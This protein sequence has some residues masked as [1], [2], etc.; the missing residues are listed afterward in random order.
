MR[1]KMI[2]ILWLLAVASVASAD[3]SYD[4]QNY[5]EGSNIGPYTCSDGEWIRK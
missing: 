2:I 1:L 5:P 3:C 4:G